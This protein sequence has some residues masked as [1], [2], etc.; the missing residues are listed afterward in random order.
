MLYIP[1]HTLL[2][3]TDAIATQRRTTYD[4]YSHS[5]PWYGR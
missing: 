3:V 1:Y 5:D 2:E 4:K